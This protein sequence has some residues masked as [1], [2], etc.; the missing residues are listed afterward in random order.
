MNSSE[1]HRFQSPTTPTSSSG[2]H[3]PLEGSARS[4]W[5]SQISDKIPFRPFRGETKDY[6][7]ASRF[8]RIGNCAGLK[9]RKFFQ[10]SRSSRSGGVGDGK[11]GG[12]RARLCPLSPCLCSAGVPSENGLTLIDS[13]WQRRRMLVILFFLEGK[14]Y[15]SATPALCR[16]PTPVIVQ[17]Q[18]AKLSASRRLFRRE[19]PEQARR[20]PQKGGR[21]THNAFGNLSPGCTVILRLREH[22]R[23]S[24]SELIHE[25]VAAAGFVALIRTCLA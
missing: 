7:L 19:L 17:L 1:L 3:F 10:R 25:T 13:S 23:R 22:P 5:T 24:S 4:K 8:G 9:C 2:M 21:S 15:P 20:W 11:S 18:F 12:K 14:T 6:R 16:R